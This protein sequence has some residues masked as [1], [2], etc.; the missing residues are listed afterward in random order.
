MP[1]LNVSLKTGKAFPR[2]NK[3]KN[4]ELPLKAAALFILTFLVIE[5]GFYKNLQKLVPVD[6][7]Y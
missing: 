5:I 2:S 1:E 3:G 6:M 7:P 4:L